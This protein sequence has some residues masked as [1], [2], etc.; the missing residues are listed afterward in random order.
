MGGTIADLHEVVNL[1][2]QGALRIDVELFPFERTVE[3]YETVRAG[4]TAIT[5]GDKEALRQAYDAVTAMTGVLGLS[6]SDF[7]RTTADSSLRNVV[8]ALVP[9]ML[10]ARAAARARKDY[11]ESDRIRDALAA[12]GILVEDTPAGARW[13]VGPS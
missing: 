9:A 7:A 11:A 1:A 2:E 10:E 4:N 12:A 8:D 5:D 6:P 3:A 13:R